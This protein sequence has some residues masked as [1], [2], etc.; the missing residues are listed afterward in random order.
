MRKR[1]VLVWVFIALLGCARPSWAGLYDPTQPLQPVPDPQEFL[2]RQLAELRSLGPPDVLL[3]GQ[4]SAARDEALAR[5]QHLR[6]QGE[7][8]SAA[9]TAALGALLI[10]VRR[11]QP[12]GQDF[13]E[14][15]Q[16]LEAA[17]RRFP[18]DFYILTNLAT[19]YQLTG[20]LDAAASLLQEALDY[21]PPELRTLERYHLQLVRERSREQV[22][23]GLAPLD[24]L[25]LGPDRTP[26]RYVGPQG[27]W[28]VGTLADAER[29]KLPN[30]SV[31][32]AMRIVQH[33]L[34]WF[35]DDARLM[36]QFGELANASG[37]LKTAAL[38]L[39]QAVYNFRLSTPQLKERRFIL[40]EAVA[41][42]EVLGRA[43]DEDRQLAWL[44]QTVAASVPGLPQPDV[45]GVMVAQGVALPRPKD[46][47][48]GGLLIGGA[49]SSGEDPAEEPPVNW[50]ATVSWQGWTAVGVGVAVMLL[51]FAL[52]L[53][54]WL[55]KRT[56]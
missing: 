22:T 35:P 26:V 8:L 27:E 47:F 34:L 7:R 33:L 42:R 40:Q 12:G 23:L 36:W 19:A 32:E 30:G 50:I 2:L 56:T 25:F 14:A 48:G 3:G 37:D 45:S 4:T 21:A 43:G 52:Q 51:L 18:R 1:T 29:A 6:Q 5:I 13:E 53:R 20:R 38:A 41:W 44:L 55:R 49:G 9:D 11:T 39:G 28:Q 15:L 16:V 31:A 46:L 54:E 24:R 10:R 17:R